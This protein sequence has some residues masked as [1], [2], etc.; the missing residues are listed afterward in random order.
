MKIALE[1][2][3]I[4]CVQCGTVFKGHSLPDSSYGERLLYTLDGKDFVYVNFILENTFKDL[5]TR[6][7]QLIKTNGISLGKRTEVFNKCIPI[8]C[9]SITGKKID[10]FRLSPCCIICSSNQVSTNN[11]DQ[12]QSEYVEVMTVTHSLWN[13]F[14]DKEKNEAINF[15]INSLN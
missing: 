10:P 9:D 3:N 13:K 8:V 11:D 6:I 1:I 2:L 5:D 14:N 12:K 4:K 7:N 15:I